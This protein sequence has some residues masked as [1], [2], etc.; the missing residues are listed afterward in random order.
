[1]KTNLESSFEND[2]SSMLSGLGNER[3]SKDEAKKLAFQRAS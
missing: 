3:N 2:K 1:M